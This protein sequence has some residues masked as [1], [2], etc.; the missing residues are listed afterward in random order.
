M[1]VLKFTHL[2]YSEQVTS[3]MGPFRCVLCACVCV[4]AE[5]REF[6]L[7]GVFYDSMQAC[8]ILNAA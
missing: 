8:N 7:E 4:C 1:C 2:V 5:A 3:A 6:R